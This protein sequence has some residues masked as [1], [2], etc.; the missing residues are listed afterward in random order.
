MMVF[1]YLWQKDISIEVYM[2]SMLKQFSLQLGEADAA[3]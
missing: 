1:F 3:S 2:I